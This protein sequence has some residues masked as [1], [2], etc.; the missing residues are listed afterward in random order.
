[1]TLPHARRQ[2]HAGALLRAVIARYPEKTWRVPATLPEEFSGV[3]EKCGFTREKLSQ[4][5]MD[6]GLDKIK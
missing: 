1:V 2:G 6:T 5:Q 4:W 3:F